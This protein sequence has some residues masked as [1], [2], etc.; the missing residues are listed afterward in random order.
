MPPQNTL[1][2]TTHV[3]PLTNIIKFIIKMLVSCRIKLHVMR[4]EQPLIYY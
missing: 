2:K 1:I 3:S 4:R